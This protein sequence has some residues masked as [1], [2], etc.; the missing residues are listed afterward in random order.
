MLRL[1]DEARHL[2]AQGRDDL[3]LRVMSEALGD[4]PC[5]AARGCRCK[6]LG[7]ALREEIRGCVAAMVDDAVEWAQ[8]EGW[9]AAECEQFAA[10]LHRLGPSSGPR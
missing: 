6:S 7:H 1:R 9:A 8:A 4:R 2:H 5:G 3:A 10:A